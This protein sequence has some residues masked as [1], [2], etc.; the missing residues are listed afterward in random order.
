MYDN[1]NKDG[2]GS[3]TEVILVV[4]VPTPVQ[5]TTHTSFGMSGTPH[6]MVQG[7]AA[8][9][10]KDQHVASVTHGPGPGV[11]SGTNSSMSRPTMS[12]NTYMLSG[13]GVV[14]LAVDPHT[15]NSTNTTVVIQ[16]PCQTIVQTL[17]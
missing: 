7:S 10:R 2:V 14:R 11:A 5:H 13:S 16:S 8:L 1:T 6:I 4:M 9:S 3:I 12:S 15:G 17:S